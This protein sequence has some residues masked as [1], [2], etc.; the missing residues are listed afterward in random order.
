MRTL[1]TPALILDKVKLQQNLSTFQNRLLALGV[2]L[3]PHGK[4]A[5][6]IDVASL[7]LAGQ[8][9]A[10]TVSTLREA[11][12]YFEHGITD[13]T[14]AVGIAPSKLDHVCDLIK[15]GAKMK[16]ILDSAAQVSLA[17]AKAATHGVILPVLIEIDCDGHRSGVQPDDQLLLDLA[18]QIVESQDLM[19]RGILTHAGESYA[20]TSIEDITALAEQERSIAVQCAN[21]LRSNGYPCLEV[22]VGS[23]PTGRFVENLA[24][25]TEFRAGVY[26]FYDLVMEGLGVCNK[27]EIAATVLTSVIGHQHN[28]GWLITD[29][30]WMALSRDQGNGQHGSGIVCTL[31][32]TP[33]PQ[34]L[35]VSGT[36]QE[37]GIITRRD[38][39]AIDPADFPVGTLL[40]ILPNHACATAAQYGQYHVIDGSETVVDVW[41]RVN[42]W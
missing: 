18:Q 11:E 42:G 37:H 20:C 9:A 12:Y 34:D 31:D 16:I 4:T 17:A 8:P 15:R 5:K 38:G 35:I 41:D 23:T 19:L 13:L 3:R 25:V 7:A 29:A 36:N 28:K 6:N 30:G 22:S 10:L 39:G 33:H 2:R 26:M 27:E 14:Y 24:G 40:R 1:E 32:G 21:T